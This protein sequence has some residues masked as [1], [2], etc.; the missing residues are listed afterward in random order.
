[1]LVKELSA[2]SGISRHTLD[3]YLN[4]RNQTPSV[5]CAV[6][7]AQALDVSVEYLATGQELK[8][9]ESLLSLCSEAR[10]SAQIIEQLTENNRKT[11]LALIQTLKARDDAENTHKN[12]HK[13]QTASV[14]FTGSWEDCG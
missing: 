3:N 11:A 9:R 5:D 10:T 7:I 8:H 4:V 2:I 14:N 12:S 6:R 1:M 13:P